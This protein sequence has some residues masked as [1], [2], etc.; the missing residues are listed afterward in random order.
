MQSMKEDAKAIKPYKK[1]MS[2]K[3]A[4]TPPHLSGSEEKPGEKSGWQ[5]IIYK[6]SLTS[7]K[8][9]STIDRSAA[10]LCWIEKHATDVFQDE[11]IKVP[12]EECLEYINGWAGF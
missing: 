5:Q 4:K 10:R 12:S 3:N 8:N 9:R 7:N 11:K 2:I 6:C 1:D